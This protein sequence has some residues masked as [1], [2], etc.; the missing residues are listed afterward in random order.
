MLNVGQAADL[1]TPPLKALSQLVIALARG[2]LGGVP[3]LL[4]R[5]FHRANPSVSGARAAW[6]RPLPPSRENKSRKSLDIS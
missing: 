2:N 1:S 5:A 6:D 3:R 4:Q